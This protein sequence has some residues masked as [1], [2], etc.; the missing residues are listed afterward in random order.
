MAL[1]H[2]TLDHDLVSSHKLTKSEL[3]HTERKPLGGRGRGC[4]RKTSRLGFQRP[5]ETHPSPRPPLHERKEEAVASRGSLAAGG[6][7]FRLGLG[8]SAQEANR[9][10]DL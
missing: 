5:W 7:R 2:V 1:G 8:D 6:L 10:Q 4:G 9:P 3:S